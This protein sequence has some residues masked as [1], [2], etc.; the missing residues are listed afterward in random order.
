MKAMTS[1]RIVFN[2]DVSL[3]S[4]TMRGGGLG[5]MQKTMLQVWIIKV[6]N[7]YN[8]FKTPMWQLN[9]LLT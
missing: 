3:L 1:K 8:T 5:H 2:N 4:A 9:H 7:S 6:S